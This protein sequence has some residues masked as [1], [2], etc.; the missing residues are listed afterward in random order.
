M[1]VAMT[2]FFPY[3]VGKCN[4]LKTLC[5]RW[6]SVHAVCPDRTGIGEY[7]VEDMRNAGMPNVEGVVFTAQRKEEMAT[8]LKEKMLKK[9]LRIP[10][11][12]KL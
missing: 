5:D 10:Y 11:D 6:Q 2:C 4:L 7:V 3:I 1:L 9:K 8:I 12:R